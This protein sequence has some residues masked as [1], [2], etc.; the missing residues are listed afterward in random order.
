M[1]QAHRHHHRALRNLL[2]TLAV[3]SAGCVESYGAR[4]VE[5]EDFDRQKAQLDVGDASTGF[6]DSFGDSGAE[7]TGELPDICEDMDFE[8]PSCEA[9]RNDCIPKALYHKSAANEYYNECRNYCYADERCY[10]RATAMLGELDTQCTPDLRGAD[11]KWCGEFNPADKTGTCD[12]LVFKVVIRYPTG[13]GW[14]YHIATMVNTCEDGQCMIDPIGDPS[15]APTTTCVSPQDWCKRFAKGNTPVWTDTDDQPPAGKVYCEIVPAAQ[16]DY[17]DISQA[18]PTDAPTL[19]GV[20]KKLEDHVANLCAAGKSPFPP[21]CG[22][23]KDGDG[24]PDDYDLCPNSAPGATVDYCDPKR[25]GCAAG[26]VPAG[27][28]P[29][30]EAAEDS[31]GDAPGGDVPQDQPEPLPQPD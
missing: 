25:L 9:E 27:P 22:K 21:G 31:G 7:D 16:G 3:A 28:V 2:A 13:A 5:D 12:D 30:E 20:C 15:K 19:G 24:I 29:E 10:D 14:S 18:D 17:R 1:T 6:D 11:G 23:D 26:E 8:L 4:I